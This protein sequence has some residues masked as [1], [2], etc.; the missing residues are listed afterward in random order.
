M[1][2]RLQSVLGKLHFLVTLIVRK[3][4][5]YSTL[6]WRSTFQ[7]MPPR[8]ANS[9]NANVRNASATPLVLDQEVS[10]VVFRNSTKLLA[11]SMTTWNNKKVRVPTNN[12]RGSVTASI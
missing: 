10:I 2:G 1:R 12:N 9:R 8:R 4:W 11:Q 5:S 3:V 6:T 7:I